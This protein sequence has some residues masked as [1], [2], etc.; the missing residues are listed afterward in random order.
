MKVKGLVTTASKGWFDQLCRS[1]NHPTFIQTFMKKPATAWFETNQTRETSS[2]SCPEISYY[3]R[4]W[5]EHL[6]WTAGA[7]PWQKLSPL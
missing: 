2:S 5:Q 6:A 7:D 4:T 3:L 1:R